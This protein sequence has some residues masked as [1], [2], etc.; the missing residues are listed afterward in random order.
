[1]HMTELVALQHMYATNAER[2]MICCSL[3]YMNNCVIQL[4]SSMLS[5]TRL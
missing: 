5:G 1:M 2:R 3:H 4:Q